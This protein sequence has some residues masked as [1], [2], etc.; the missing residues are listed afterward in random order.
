MR[1]INLEVKR[2]KYVQYFFLMSAICFIVIGLIRGEESVVL[3]KATNICLEC[4]GIG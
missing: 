1:R 4:I 2:R 3:K